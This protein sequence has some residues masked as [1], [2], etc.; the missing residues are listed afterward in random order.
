MGSSKDELI[1]TSGQ[2]NYYA[3]FFFAEGLPE[4]V[5]GVASN[6]QPG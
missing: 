1:Q 3:T 4:A 5:A 6:Q 2:I